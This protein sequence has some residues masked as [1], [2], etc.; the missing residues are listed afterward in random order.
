MGNHNFFMENKK[1][2]KYLSAGKKCYLEKDK[3]AEMIFC[4]VSLIQHETAF[5]L[6]ATKTFVLTITAECLRNEILW[7]WGV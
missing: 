1:N 3:H 6:T 7:R 2:V 5:I 4:D